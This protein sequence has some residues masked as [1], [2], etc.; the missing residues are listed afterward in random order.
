MSRLYL[1]SYFSYLMVNLSK[2]LVAWVC[3][4]SG[5]G[6]FRSFFKRLWGPNSSTLP[7]NTHSYSH[8]YRVSPLTLKLTAEPSSN[9]RRPV[10]SAFHLY[11]LLCCCLA[12]RIYSSATQDRKRRKRWRRLGEGVSGWLHN[13]DACYLQPLQVL[14]FQLVMPATLQIGR[15]SGRRRAKIST[16]VITKGDNFMG[17]HKVINTPDDICE[18]SKHNQCTL[19]IFYSE[20]AAENSSSLTQITMQPHMLWRMFSEGEDER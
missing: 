6:E 1:I 2:F 18:T 9:R 19:Y 12:G 11:V 3:R 10:P 8:T 5:D 7:S 16:A 13:A 15:R 14:G 17:L 4:R 20:A